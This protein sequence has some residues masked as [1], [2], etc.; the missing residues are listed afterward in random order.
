[1]SSLILKLSVLGALV[2][3][4][5]GCVT[6]NEKTWPI[7]HRPPGLGLVNNISDAIATAATNKVYGDNCVK[8]GYYTMAYGHYS[9]ALVCIVRALKWSQ[10]FELSKAWF[11][12][13]LYSQLRTVV[14][15]IPELEEKYRELEHNPK[16]EYD[17]NQRISMHNST[18]LTAFWKVRMVYPVTPSEVSLTEADVG[19]NWWERR[20]DIPPPTL[21]ASWQEAWLAVQER[22][23][24]LEEYLKDSKTP[25]P[26][27]IG[28]IVRDLRERGIIGPEPPRLPSPPPRRVSPKAPPDNTA[29]GVPSVL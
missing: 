28:D 1:M 20:H 27:P 3:A 23:R 6:I 24:L 12:R 17:E 25:R 7:M 5:P 29:T 22:M 13:E 4:F 9:L 26:P 8:G 14:D 11:A 2:A 21:V 19:P 10:E 18:E 16:Y 15:L